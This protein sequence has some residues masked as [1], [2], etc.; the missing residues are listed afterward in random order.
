MMRSVLRFFLVNLGLSGL[1]L[2]I[3]AASMRN[4]RLERLLWPFVITMV[5]SNVIGILAWNLLPRLAPRL[6]GKG[7]WFWTQYLLLM[8][9]IGWAGGTIGYLMMVWQPYI[10]ILLDY[11]SSMVVC[12]AITVTMGSVMYF[13]EE[14]K[15][16]VQETTLQLR[17]RELEKERALKVASEA[18]L[19]SLESRIHPHFLFNTLNSISAL[20][21]QDPAK[22]EEIIERLAALLRFSLDRHGGVVSLADELQ[23]TRDYLAIEEARFG[24]RLRYRIEV[25]DELRGTLVPAL[26]LQTLAENSV[27][28]AVGV[29]RA[30]AEIVVSAESSGGS[31]WLRVRDTGPGFDSVALPAGH[32]LDGLRERLQ[33]LFGEAA[34][35]EAKRLEGGMEVGMRVPC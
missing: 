30:G 22:A 7:L 31:V 2:V 16:K 5:Y 11:P 4:P 35:L 9:M 23:V 27:K 10:R 28:Y 17:T 15:A 19:Q 24:K 21:R 18:K 8:V 34:G 12:C 33:S 20:V 6:R 14:A 25:P 1:F 26:S 32:G 13:I 3:N 29:S